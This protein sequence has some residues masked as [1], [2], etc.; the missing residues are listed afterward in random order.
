MELS[1]IL[2]LVFI[3]ALIMMNA[4]FAAA[5]IAIVSMRRTRLMEL[6]E[7][8][9]AGARAALRL[10]GN[11]SRFLATIQVGVTLAGFF[12][13]ALGAISLVVLVRDLL[14]A[15]PI[16]FIA[17]YSGPISFV[18]VTMGISF[19]TLVLG[20]LA[21][22]NLGIHYA[23]AISR[24]I[25][26]P[27]ELLSTLAAPMVIVLTATTNAI[28]AVFRIEERASIPAVS[29]SEI[30]SM[31]EAGE[32]EGVIES[33]EAEMI[34][35]VFDLGETRAH[36]IMVPRVDILAIRKDAQIDEALDLYVKSGYSRFPVF[37]GSFDSIVGILYAKD[38][39]RVLAKGERPADIALLVRPALFVP[40]TKRV[41]DLLKELQRTR[42]HLA[43][44]VDEFGGTAGLVTLEDILEEIVGDIRD[45]HEAEQ[46]IIE[47]ND[48]REAVASGVTTLSE[49]NEALDLHLA[50]KDFDTLGGL[51]LSQLGRIPQ[52]GEVV[53]LPE[54]RITVMAINGLR[55]TKVRVQKKEAEAA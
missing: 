30:V 55:V 9:D 3:V 1:F 23:E 36:G 33:S 53:E 54:A 43:V 45:E 52:P 28:L 2:E 22:K 24:L 34:E 5:E 20:E 39:L 12:A 21:P 49:I 19:A 42:N 15:V 37:D 31:V 11:P 13:S 25:A 41:G 32:E 48:S 14:S 7:R 16:P 44:V 47:L 51:V 40:E 10:I 35:R 26:P 27:I 18:A 29:P 6:A 46:P 8:G 50:G 4:F 17:N 38:L